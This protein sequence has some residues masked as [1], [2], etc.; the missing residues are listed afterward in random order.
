MTSTSKTYIVQED[1]SLAAIIDWDGI[2]AVPRCVGNEKFPSWLTRDWDTAKYAYG[3]TFEDGEPTSEDSPSHL[4]RYRSM[5]VRF[6]REYATTVQYDPSTGR[7]FLVDNLYIAA[8]DPV[9][10]HGIVEKVFDESL[11]A[12]N[13]RRKSN[14]ADTENQDELYLY[15][16]VTELEDGEFNR[17]QLS[18]VR[19]GFLALC[20]EL[21]DLDGAFWSAIGGGDRTDA[22]RKTDKT[23]AYPPVNTD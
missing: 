5:Y 18:A 6:M 13:W 7:S 10:A 11:R 22:D 2:A 14:E 3:R 23:Y 17:A 15:E 12:R 4:A 1:G 8:C 21:G 9:R 20:A 19:E 16:F